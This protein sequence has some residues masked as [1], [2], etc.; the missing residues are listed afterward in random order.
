[1]HTG[2]MSRMTTSFASLLWA[3]P[4]MRR[5][6]SRGGRAGWVEPLQHAVE[7]L[8]RIA[9]AG[10]DRDRRELEHAVRVLPVEE[11]AELVGADQEHRVVEPAVAEHVDGSL[12]R[13][14][15]HA[16]VGEGGAREAK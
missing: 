3:R 8:A 15:L 12:V 4:A 7:P 6:C 9:R 1:M 5:A 14:E 16:T 2:R 13:V 10:G 11:V